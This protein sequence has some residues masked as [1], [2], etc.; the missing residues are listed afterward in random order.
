MVRMYKNRITEGS[1]C[2]NSANE[3]VPELLSDNNS[4]FSLIDIK[5]WFSS[6][7]APSIGSAPPVFADTSSEVSSVL[8]ITTLSE[9][10]SAAAADPI[11][12]TNKSSDIIKKY[13]FDLF[14]EIISFL[15]KSKFLCF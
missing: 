13:F 7:D 1:S 10:A 4:V 14:F 15:L 12:S 9:G 5:V 3:P 11:H 6:L 8:F 2:S